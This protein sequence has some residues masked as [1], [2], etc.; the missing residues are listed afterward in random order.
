M[1][2][3]LEKVTPFLAAAY[4]ERNTKNRRMS[5]ARVEAYAA[6]MQRGEW[7]FNGDSIRFSVDGALLDGQHRLSA[8]VKSGTTQNFLVVRGLP[9]NVFATIDTGAARTASDVI[10][11]VGVKNQNVAA[12]GARMYLNWKRNGSPGEPNTK[13]RLSNAQIL[14][15]CSDNDLL[16]RAASYVAGNTFIKKFMSPSIS[17]FSYLAFSDASEG[18]ATSFLD[19]VSNKTE[20]FADSPAFLLRERLL[21]MSGAKM[22]ATKKDKTA[23]VFKAFRLWRAGRKMKQLKVATNG[24]LLEK[25]LFSIGE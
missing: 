5:S 2:S 18:M 12:A 16:D 3:E 24:K 13:D 17:C 8:V 19:E 14:E 10:G 20:I 4:L 6:A 15:F 7:I 9:K 1:H 22:K 25:E 11:L 23:L 21:E